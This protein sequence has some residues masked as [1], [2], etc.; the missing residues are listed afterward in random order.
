[1]KTGLTLQQG[2]ATTT[3]TTTSVCCI[4]RLLGSV[5][6]AVG[7]N[8]ELGVGLGEG[9]AVEDGA[10]TVLSAALAEAEAGGGGVGDDVAAD[11]FSAVLGEAH[12]SGVGGDLVR[13]EDCDAE[14]WR[15]KQAIFV[16]AR[17]MTDREFILGFC[18]VLSVAVLLPL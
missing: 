9:G 5:A 8:G 17:R 10:D 7:S 4:Y 11:G 16:R 6:D 15:A 2:G 13:H 1:M 12:A 14:L 3:T 18:F